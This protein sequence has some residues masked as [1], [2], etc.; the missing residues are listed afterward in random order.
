MS[1]PFERPEL[2]KHDQEMIEKF[3]HRLL[4]QLN[5]GIVRLALLTL[6][7]ENIKLTKEIN[8]HREKLGYELL[9]VNEPK[10]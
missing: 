9:P 5:R 1:I 4:A 10:M 2:T 3:G 6:L 7:A 8:I